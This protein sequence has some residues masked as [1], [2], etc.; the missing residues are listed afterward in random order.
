MQLFV[1]DMAD[2]I[3][4][5]LFVFLFV[6][7][8]HDG[9]AARNETL[10]ENFKTVELSNF[11][12]EFINRC[13]LVFKEID[14]QNKSKRL[15]STGNISRVS[16]QLLSYF[17][18]V[19]RTLSDISRYSTPASFD[20][21]ETGFNSGHSAVFF[22]ELHPSVRYHGWDLGTEFSASKHSAELL[23]HR[24][25][26][27]IELVW[28]DSKITVPRHLNSTKLKCDIISVDGEHTYE[29]SL[30]DLRHFI[31]ASKNTSLVLVDDCDN[32]TGILRAFTEVVFKDRL[33]QWH[34]RVEYAPD[35]MPRDMI[36]H[37]RSKSHCVGRYLLSSDLLNR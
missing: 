10:Q 28:G 36:P 19:I 20:I 3:C 11:Y 16:R 12:D 26:D 17:W 7:L 5:F 30:S 35:G 6:F 15:S 21:C 37:F 8:L 24:Y 22:L 25:G 32:D 1:S 34:S 23:K 29:G 2:I 33:I 9:F 13:R 27:R 18:L 31:H 14:T 4:R